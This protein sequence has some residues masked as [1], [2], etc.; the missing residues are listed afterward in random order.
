M[1]AVSGRQGKKVDVKEVDHVTLPTV[2]QHS[3]TEL[4]LWNNSINSTVSTEQS[5]R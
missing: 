2:L 4:C 3:K 1:M 5:N